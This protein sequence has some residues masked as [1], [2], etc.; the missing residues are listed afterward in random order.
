[1]SSLSLETLSKD[2]AKE[3]NLGAMHNFETANA[4]T[5]NQRGTSKTIFAAVQTTYGMVVKSTSEV[6]QVP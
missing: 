6:L 2:A 3:L 1:M 5:S 4:C